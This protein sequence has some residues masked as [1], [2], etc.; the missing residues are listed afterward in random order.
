MG[1]RGGFAAG[2]K[3][4]LSKLSDRC[5]I[6]AG[7]HHLF[8][9]GRIVGDSLILQLVEMADFHAYGLIGSLP[10]FCVEEIAERT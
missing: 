6:T 3:C 7:K 1:V 8:S 5:N 4:S 10:G 9:D 2:G